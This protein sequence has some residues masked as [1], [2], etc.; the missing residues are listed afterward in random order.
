MTS[1]C[2][3]RD[4][5]AEATDG[6]EHW[7]DPGADALE[8]G[9]EIFTKGTRVEVKTRDDIWRAGTVVETWDDNERAIVVECDERW[10]DNLDNYDGRG[11]TIM[12]Y[13]NTYRGIRSRIRL[14]ND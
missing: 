7:D 3:K 4:F 8:T 6:R 11:A 14:L 9:W 5:L 1:Q 2:R 12:V 10:H 13:M